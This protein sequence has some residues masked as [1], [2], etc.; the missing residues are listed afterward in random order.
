MSFPVLLCRI[1]C[2]LV[3]DLICFHFSSQPLLPWDVS[4][5]SLSAI[6]R[7]SSI[8]RFPV[9]GTFDSLTLFYHS[10][11]NWL[12]SL[13]FPVLSLF[14][15]FAPSLEF[16]MESIS[17][18]FCSVVTIWVFPHSNISVNFLVPIL[19]RLAVLITST[20]SLKVKHFLFVEACGAEDFFRFGCAF[21]KVPPRL[22]ALLLKM[23]AVLF[24]VTEPEH[25]TQ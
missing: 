8:K 2:T 14:C 17:S 5:P 24:A 3:F 9:M 1:Y 22:S 10:H 15:V 13:Y 11:N 21:E 6:N 12:I 23:L 25:A 7:A 18:L 16:H 19:S 20:Y 4:S